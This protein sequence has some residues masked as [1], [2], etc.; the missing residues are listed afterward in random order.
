MTP[1]FPQKNP[2]GPSSGRYHVI[3][4]GWWEWCP[5][6]YICHENPNYRSTARNGTGNYGRGGS[7]PAWIYYTGAGFRC[8]EGRR[9]NIAYS[10]S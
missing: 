10:I 1:E 5:S 8:A 4:G 6:N 2:Q 7:G 3:Q 9:G